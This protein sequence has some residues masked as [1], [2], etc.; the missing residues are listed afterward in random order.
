MKTNIRLIFT[1]DYEIHGNGDGSPYKL[2]IEPTIRL[3]NLFDKYNA[4]VTIFADVAEILCF[5]SYYEE[6][7]EDRF[8]YKEIISQL[9]DAIKRG[10]DVQ[11]HIHSSYFGAKFNGTKWEQKWENY[12]LAALSYD[13]INLIIKTTKKF[14]EDTLKQVDPN[15]RCDAFRAANWSM[16][17]TYNIY[18]ALV[19]N[20]IKIDSSVYKWGRQFGRVDYNYMDA[21]SNIFPYK[22][23]SNNINLKDDNG[24]LVEF[25][26][27]TEFRHFWH[28]ISLM[29]IFR[30]IRSRF[31]SD[32][33]QRKISEESKDYKR[34]TLKSFLR[35]NP[36]KLDFNQASAGQLINTLEKIIIK[37]A[38]K[39]DSIPVVCI[40]HSKSF[41][42]YNEKRIERFLRF[43]K[44]HKC[45]NF[46]LFNYQE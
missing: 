7:G 36:W 43:A 4:K 18:N 11:L 29:R 20:E 40:G 23:N 14:I 8:H 27:Y 12:N 17:P 15:Y 38:D 33:G 5:K 24:Q 2:M 46:S 37:Y 21:Y 6:T 19:S 44:D 32:K 25:P 26:I 9:Q 16:M 35:R 34:L 42:R 30:M 39:S 41:L 45:I 10:H 13:E 31:H 1:L 3:L 22:A 28:F